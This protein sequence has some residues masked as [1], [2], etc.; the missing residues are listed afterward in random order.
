MN[1]PPDVKKMLM[2]YVAAWNSGDPEKVAF[3]LTDDC[4]FE[5]LGGEHVHRGNEGVKAWATGVFASIP[6]FKLE[7]RSLFV[8]GDWVGCE[9]IETGT[10]T[11]AVGNQPPTG[12]SFS[13]PSA[14]ILEVHEGKIRREALYWDS[15]TFL[16]QLGLTPEGHSR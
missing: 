6:D 5:N 14:S 15:A 10:Q 11:G 12:K 16:R 9:W 4:V 2:D 1:M 7:V 13:V 8:A 3:F